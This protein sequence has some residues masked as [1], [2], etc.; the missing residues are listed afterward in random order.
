MEMNG[1]TAPLYNGGMFLSLEDLYEW[2]WTLEHMD[3]D[4]PVREL[5]GI[6]AKCVLVEFGSLSCYGWMYDEL[7]GAL[8]EQ[9][10]LAHRKV[11]CHSPT[12]VVCMGTFGP[13]MSLG[14]GYVPNPSAR[15]HCH[16]IL[17]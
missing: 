3:C 16:N 13:S 9:G 1:D 15:W 14:V 8:E 17:R 7:R 12:I 2:F 11:F 4:T 10:L 5:Y 6:D